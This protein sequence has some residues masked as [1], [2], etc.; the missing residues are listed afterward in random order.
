MNYVTNTT[1]TASFT[2]VSVGTTSTDITK[3]FVEVQRPNGERQMVGSVTSAS[4]GDGVVRTVVTTS[5]D[6]S[7]TGT[8]IIKLFYT[9]TADA[10]TSQTGVLL[11]GTAVFQKVTTVTT[12]TV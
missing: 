4:A 2:K 12:I 8:Y 3:Y 7:V 9:P 5:L 1:V 11:L 6:C 10:D